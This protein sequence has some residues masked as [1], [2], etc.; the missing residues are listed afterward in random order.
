MKNYE[1]QAA[2]LKA[3][4]HPFRLKIVDVLRAEPECVCHL[5]AAL[6]KPQPYVSQQLAILRNA[7]V[8]L[9]ERDGT[10]I[11]YRLA[12]EN[13]AR[14]VAAACADCDAADPNGH[15]ADQTR[16][17]LPNCNCPKCAV[18]HG[19]NVEAYKVAC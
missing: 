14:Q 7:R 18:A 17:A 13:V 1:R 11:Y 5:A 6:D 10:N 15:G 12:D 4:A 19:L 3:I 2:L 16:Q 9:D 8:I